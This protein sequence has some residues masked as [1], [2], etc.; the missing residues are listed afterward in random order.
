VIKGFIQISSS[1]HLKTLHGR[2]KL[3]KYLNSAQKLL[4][5]LPTVVHVAKNKQ[6]FCYPVVCMFVKFYISLV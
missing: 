6:L 2:K 4:F 5:S 1:R 3:T